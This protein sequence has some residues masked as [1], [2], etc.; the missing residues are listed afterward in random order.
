MNS[1]IVKSGMV[2]LAGREKTDMTDDDVTV[3]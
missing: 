2:M 3:S 1:E